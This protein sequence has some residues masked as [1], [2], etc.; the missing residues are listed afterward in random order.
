MA[1]IVGWGILGT[2]TMAGRFARALRDVPHARLVAAASRSRAGAENFGAAFAV[3]CTYA[4]YA[5]L[6]ED[7]RV[8]VVYVATPNHTHKGHCLLALGAGKAVLCEKPFTVNAP[9]AREV[10][11][12]ARRQRLFCM[13]AMW[14]RFLPIMARLRGVLESGAIGEIRTVIADLGFPTSTEE[15]RLLL[16]PELGRGAMLDL[17]IYPLSLASSLLGRPNDIIS[18]ALLDATGV[19]EQS[20]A[21]LGYAGGQFA[22]VSASLRGRLPNEAIIIGDRGQIRVHAPLHGPHKLSLS[23]FAAAGSH[24][25]GRCGWRAR[26]R[27]NRLLRAVYFRFDDI[28]DILLKRGPKKIVA[29]LRG[30]G[31]NYEAAEV[32]RCLRAGEVESRLM[33]LDETLTIMETMDMIR[34][35]WNHR[36]P[37]SQ[38]MH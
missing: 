27:E 26:L 5:E 2:G 33:P 34:R 13:E 37:E 1:D 4:T 28:F 29:P 20:V 3:P 30:N 25:A 38:S 14:T 36:P 31:Y 11:A 10:I 23:E 6:V 12:L 7:D 15:D 19:D 8:D 24:P 18:R 21:V 32:T 16:R 35:S 17:G 22:V 9:E